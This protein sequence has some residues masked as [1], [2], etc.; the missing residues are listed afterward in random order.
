MPTATDPISQV[1]ARSLFQLAEQAGGETKI[2]EVAEELEQ[3]SEIVRSDRTFAEY[4]ALEKMSTVRHEY[5]DGA[6]WAM[7]GGSP[8]HAGIAGNVVALLSTQLREQPCRVFGS[9]L[10]GRVVATGLGTYPDVSVVCGHLEL[11]PDD[12]KGHTVTN[13]RLVVEVLS[14]STEEYDRGEKLAH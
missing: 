10:K 5:L 7:A 1:Y 8:E 12:T 14:P 11:D 4:V 9:A 2:N 3:I 6:V 13:P